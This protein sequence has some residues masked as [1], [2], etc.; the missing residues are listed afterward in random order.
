MRLVNR[1]SS[2]KT[3]YV[4]VDAALGPVPLHELKTLHRRAAGGVAV[5]A[6]IPVVDDQFWKGAPPF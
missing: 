6:P 2:S 4:S 5:G 3:D 1:G